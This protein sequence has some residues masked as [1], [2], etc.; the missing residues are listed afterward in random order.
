MARSSRLVDA[1]AREKRVVLWNTVCR[2][3]QGRGLLSLPSPDMA[4]SSRLV[5]ADGA[6]R[7]EGAPR[8][9]DPTGVH[10]AAGERA[11]GPVT[12]TVTAAQ[13][14]SRRQTGARRAPG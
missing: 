2:L 14:R 7:S 9:A 6:R 10:S 8:P 4:R 11:S 5:G 12:V 1:G 3:D 13:S